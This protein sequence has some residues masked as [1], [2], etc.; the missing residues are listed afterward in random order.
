M[1]KVTISYSSL[2]SS[3]SEAKQ[4]SKKLKSY[5]KNLDS[6]IYKKLNKYTGDYTT[7]ISTA[8]SKTHAKIDELEA[9]AEAFSNYADDLTDL[10][11]ECL[12]TDK[13]VKSKVSKLTASFKVANGIRNSKVQNALNYCLTSFGNSTVAGRWVGNATEKFI[14][15]DDYI[16]QSIK[17]WWNYD[18]GKQLTK[19]V[20]EGVVKVAAAVLTIVL[21]ITSG[22]ALL[23]IIAGLVVGAIA[24]V[25]GVMN[26]V[27][28]GRAYNETKNNA[29][30]ALGRR[31]SNE[32]TVQDTIRRESD[33]SLCHGIAQGID[34]VNF[35]CGVVLFV[36]EAGKL[37]EK[38]YKWATGFNQVEN[39]SKKD[40]LF[41]KDNWSQFFSKMK[42]SIGDGLT[43]IGQSIKLRNFKFIKTG[44]IDFGTDFLKNLNNHFFNF[45]NPIKG[46]KS[47]SNLLGVA[48]N[49]LSDGFNK[50]NFFE[51]IVFPNVTIAN[52]ITIGT[53]EGGQMYFDPSGEIF[54]GDIYDIGDELVNDIIGNDIFSSDP[55]FNADTLKTLS[56]SCDIDISIPEINM[57]SIEMPALRA[58]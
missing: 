49:L 52:Y 54:L 50:K 19:G 4:V 17:E 18:G 38:G 5:A 16:K 3:S 37:I 55:I 34:V 22:A 15:A 6:A 28:E 23:V 33:S 58:G 53:G 51:D 56:S 32:D 43:N 35:V 26:I 2:K 36:N 44:M 31:R 24:A 20:L 25:N 57:P 41:S 45:E 12:A 13:S 46:V 27:N 9:R 1:S 30:P 21:A 8:K 39:I 10:R 14:S 29:N 47:T 7:N 42:T 11:D 40:I 48:D